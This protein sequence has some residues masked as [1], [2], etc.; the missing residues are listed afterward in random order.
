M[1]RCDVEKFLDRMLAN[2]DN[3][4]ARAKNG[5][6]ADLFWKIKRAIESL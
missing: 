3:N 1:L 6:T 4:I 5:E 2:A